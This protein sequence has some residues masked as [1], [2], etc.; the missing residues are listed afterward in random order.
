MAIPS[1]RVV[2]RTVGAKTS[3]KSMSF[4]CRCPWHTTLARASLNLPCSSSLAF[5]THLLPR[6]MALFGISLRLTMV[7]VPMAV[8]AASSVST[9]ACQCADNGPDMACRKDF[10]SRWEI[11]PVSV[12]VLTVMAQVGHVGW[13]SLKFSQLYSFSH[14]S[15][16]LMVL[17]RSTIG[18]RVSTDLWER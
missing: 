12:V 11:F 13:S 5:Q 8:W 16:M 18:S 14:H 6:R 1:L 10:G 15:S 17:W 4:R 7:Q 9:A 2:Q 3:W